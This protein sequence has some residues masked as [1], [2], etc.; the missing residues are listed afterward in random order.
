MDATIRVFEPGGR[1]QFIMDGN[2][3]TVP[4]AFLAGSLSFLS[5][6]VL[7]LVPVYLGYLS[8]STVHGN[9]AAPRAQVFMHALLFVAGFTLVFI[10][11]FGLP[12]TL[13]GAALNQYSDFIAKIGGILVILFGLH[14]V[15]LLSIPHLNLTRHLE[16]KHSEAP[17]YMRSGLIGVAF[18]AG[19]S[20]CI[21]PLLGSVISLAFVH[22]ST[23]VFFTFV[24]AMGLAVP[25]LIT[26]LLLTRATNF[27]RRLNRHAHIVQRVSGVFLIAVGLLLISGH[28]SSMNAF[29]IKITPSWLLDHL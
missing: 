3:I 27:L 5:P 15:G 18:A 16:I 7:P 17:G 1:P 22:P 23:G 2:S 28:F 24:Y 10:V 19:W 4:L 8:G 25:F 11:L 29:F 9:D 26:A 13:L 20:P 21:G 14:T 12:A 6:C